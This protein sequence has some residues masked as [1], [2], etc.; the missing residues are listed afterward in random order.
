MTR[1]GSA[2]G[3]TSPWYQ[4]KNDDTDKRIAGEAVLQ[5]VDVRLMCIAAPIRMRCQVAL[6][7]YKRRRTICVGRQ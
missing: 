4:G 6:D 7:S 1:H 2:K 5:A 3:Q